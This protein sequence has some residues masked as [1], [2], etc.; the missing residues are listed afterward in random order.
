MPPRVGNAV[1][2]FSTP[3]Q[4]VPGPGFAARPSPSSW[5]RL[6]LLREVQLDEAGLGTDQ[7]P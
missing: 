7:P 3:K 5:I 4:E 6:G 2:A 1:P